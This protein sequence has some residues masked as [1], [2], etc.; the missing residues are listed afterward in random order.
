[1]GAG[2]TSLPRRHYATLQAT[3][4]KLFRTTSTLMIGQMIRA[5]GADDVALLGSSEKTTFSDQL[6]RGHR[7]LCFLGVADKA[8]MFVRFRLPASSA[9]RERW[10]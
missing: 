5:F 7:K 4:V 9:M 1:M 8:P 10:A 2:Q 6:G 3:K